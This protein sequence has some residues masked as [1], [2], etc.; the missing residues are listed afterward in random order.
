[1][2]KIGNEEAGKNLNVSNALMSVLF[3]THNILR[4][5][6]NSKNAKNMRT[7]SSGTDFPVNF[8]GKTYTLS[9]EMVES[10]W[11]SVQATNGLRYDVDKDSELTWIGTMGPYMNMLGCWGL[12]LQELR[13]GHTKMPVAREGDKM[14][15][16]PKEKYE[17]SVEGITS[18]TS[19]GNHIPT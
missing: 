3:T 7:K 15:V 18:V 4:Q 17:F 12:R 2:K 1:M 6:Q 16:V 14:N 9:R 19:R 11:K 13:V 5:R 8:K 10:V